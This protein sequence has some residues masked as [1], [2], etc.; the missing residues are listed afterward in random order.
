MLL[1]KGDFVRFCWNGQ[2]YHGHVHEDE[3]LGNGLVNVKTEE[4]LWYGV[5]RR[6]ITPLPRA[7]SGALPRP[8]PANN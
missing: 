5:S 4:G 2:W 3:R 8:E 6:A 1:H 7:Q